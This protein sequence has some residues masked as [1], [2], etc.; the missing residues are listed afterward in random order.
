MIGGLTIKTIIGGLKEIKNKNRHPRPA[1]ILFF[2]M[3][4]KFPVFFSNRL[5]VRKIRGNE[6]NLFS[7]F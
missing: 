5:A 7:V 6:W 1:S 2:G 3:R 4:F